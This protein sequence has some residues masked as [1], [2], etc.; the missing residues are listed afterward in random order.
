M[1]R[2]TNIVYIGWCLVLTCIERFI[3]TVSCF[4]SYICCS[5][6]CMGW[7]TKFNNFFLTCTETEASWYLRALLSFTESSFLTL[8]S[9]LL[10]LFSG[11]VNCIS[12]VFESK[13]VPWR[14][15]VTKALIYISDLVVLLFRESSICIVCTISDFFL[16]C[17]LWQ[18]CLYIMYH[19]LEVSR[20]ANI[21]YI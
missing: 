15:P 9:I 3:S 12:W 6:N 10:L 4:F 7:V 8:G 1:W 21:V 19:S 18:S 5:V 16:V 17:K 14:C 13:N 2:Y 11:S 20:Y